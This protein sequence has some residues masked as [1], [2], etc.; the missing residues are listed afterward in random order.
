MAERFIF[1][2][3]LE[4]S[5]KIRRKKMSRKKLKSIMPVALRKFEKENGI[6]YKPWMVRHFKEWMEREAKLK[7]LNNERI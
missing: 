3:I 4:H 5:E 6:K 1:T 2:T 7:E